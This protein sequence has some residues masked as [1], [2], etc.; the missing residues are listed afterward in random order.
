MKSDGYDKTSIGKRF[1][2]S[3]FFANIY[4][5]LLFHIYLLMLIIGSVIS[6]AIILFFAELIF[7]EYVHIF[8]VSMTDRIFTELV[9]DHKYHN[10]IALMETKKDLIEK[11]NDP[12][13]YREKLADCYVH[14]GDYP[15]ALEQYRL[16]RQDIERRFKKNIPTY[17]TAEEVTNFKQIQDAILLREEFRIYLKMGD[18]ASIRK[19][20]M[21][22]RERYNNIDRNK[23]YESFTEKQRKELDKTPEADI[24]RNGFK[25]EL[26]KGKYLTDPQAGIE[27]MERFANSVVNSRTYNHLY[28]LQQLNELLRMLLEQGEPVKARSYL[29]LALQVYD[30]VEYNSTV[31]PELGDLSDYCY[32]LND[33]ENSR[34]L[35]KKYLTHID[36]TYDESAIEYALAHF[37][38]FKFLQTDGKWEELSERV[39]KSCNSLRT[40]I[41]DNFTGMTAAQRE[42]FIKQFMPIFNYVN[43]LTEVKPTKEIISVAFD[44]NMFIRGL[45]LRSENSLRN[46]IWAINDTLLIKKYNRYVECTRELIS[47]QYVSGPGNYYMK[48]KLQDEIET[49][50]KELA[51][52][53]MDFRRNNETKMVTAANLRK[54]LDKN[55][56]V[57]QIIEGNKTYYAL[58]LDKSGRVGYISLGSKETLN[59]LLDDRSGLYTDASS[60]APAMTSLFREMIGKDV[61]LT[62]FGSFNKISLSSIPIN[63]EGELLGDV[64]NIHLVVSS[65]D[66]P[67]VKSRNLLSNQIAGNTVLWGGIDYGAVNDKESDLTPV[68]EAIERGEELRPLPNSLKE[69]EAISQLLKEDNKNVILITGN[70]ATEKSFKNRNGKKDYILHISTHGFFHDSGAFQ[71]PMQNSGLLFADSQRYWMN[72]SIASTI[73]ETDGILRS[74]EI[75]NLDLTG[76]RLVVLSACQTGLGMNNSEGVYGLQRAFKLAGAQSILM[77]LWNVDDAATRELMGY[78]YKALIE[79]RNP[80][81]ALR[82]AKNQMRSSGYAPDKWIPFVLLN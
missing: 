75:A 13:K 6:I 1:I 59:Q 46:A 24:I 21:L 35:L 2:F 70:D 10:A 9:E 52:K 74:D 55:D 65:T 33:V 73:N 62:P 60:T 5:F 25:P 50:E 4:Y 37:K 22:I 82:I 58:T 39:A 76:C 36:D 7:P 56:L 67:E 17:L 77:S 3:K 78:F 47:R 15:K 57:V 79:G 54:I 19:Y 81:E 18:M 64:V 16:L 31:F 12:W 23:I 53:S 38:Y 68:N 26:I 11:C 27:E 30:S 51:V 71:N 72:D 28:K 40:Q 29:E 69:V 14:T 20:S 63:E 49:L 32:Q 48:R 8:N 66:I 80:D 61:Y 44:N 45:L 41:S 42:F 34:R 43:G